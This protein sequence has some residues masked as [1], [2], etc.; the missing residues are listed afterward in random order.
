M[1]ML[2]P[3][4]DACTYPVDDPAIQPSRKESTTIGQP[5][6]RSDRF[7]MLV[8]RSQADTGLEWKY[9]RRRIQKCRARMNLRVPN[10]DD[11]VG[12]C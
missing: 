11:I 7:G 6:Q 3:K 2:A 5:R 1:D 12:T 8:K 9:I 4:K 10:L